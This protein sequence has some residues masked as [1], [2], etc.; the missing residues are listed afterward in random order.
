MKRIA[1]S[2]FAGLAVCAMAWIGGFD[3]N[4]RGFIAFFVAYVSACAAL[5]TYWFPNWKEPK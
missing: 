5:M 2:I 4:E 3:F 1:C